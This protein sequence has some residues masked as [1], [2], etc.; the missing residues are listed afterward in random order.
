MT[1]IKT[2]EIRMENTPLVTFPTTRPK[3]LW[4]RSVLIVLNWIE[5]S[6]GCGISGKRRRRCV[7]ICDKHVRGWFF[8]DDGARRSEEILN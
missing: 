7:H 3:K 1:D 8:T 6:A 2:V 4:L 5:V